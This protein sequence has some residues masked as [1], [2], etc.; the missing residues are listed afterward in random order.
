[1]VSHVNKISYPVTINEPC[2]LPIALPVDC[3]HSKMAF[4]LVE[5]IA[6]NLR[7]PDNTLIGRVV[8]MSGNVR[9]Y[10]EKRHV[11]AEIEPDHKVLEVGFGPGIGIEEACK[12]VK[13]GKG[14]VYGIDISQEMVATATKRAE[15][16]INDGKVEL[17]N[18][19]VADLSRFGSSTFDCVFHG[20]CY[21][22]WPDM[23]KAT[24]E[25]YRVM[26]TDA[27]MISTMNYE[28]AKRMQGLGLLRYGYPD[29]GRYMKSLESCGFGGVR[30]EKN[31]K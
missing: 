21:Y 19:D 29:Q 18:G 22:F 13:G 11:C 12:Y 6:C 15:K 28:R 23:D 8:K 17:I 2:Y 7:R 3:Q 26:K 5:H 31:E 20:N 16:E 9:C 25:L 24:H 1:M 14:K 4:S 30:V 10:K 27:V